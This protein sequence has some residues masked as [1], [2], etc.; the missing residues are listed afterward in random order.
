MRLK[1]LF[2]KKQRDLQVTFIVPADAVEKAKTEMFPAVLKVTD[3]MVADAL[4][5]HLSKEIRGF[6]FQDINVKRIRTKK[7]RTK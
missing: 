5:H 6:F 7:I 2:K 4:M 3:S 1:N